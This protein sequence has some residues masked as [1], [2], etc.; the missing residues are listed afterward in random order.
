VFGGV[1]R[2]YGKT[3][4]VPV[5]DRTANTLIVVH[6]DW[7]EPSTTVISDC[8]SAYRNPETHGYAYKTVNHMI[9]F[10]YVLNGEHTNTIDSMWL[11]SSI[12]TTGWRTSTTCPNCGR[13][14]IWQRRPLRR[15]RCHHWLERD[16]STPFWYCHSVTRGSALTAVHKSYLTRPPHSRTRSVLQNTILTTDHIYL[17]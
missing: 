4:L 16:T 5:T 14:R 1:E 11:L 12:P 13:M 2:E 10:V 15:H 17:N 9:G 8:W 3:F 7:I 6:R